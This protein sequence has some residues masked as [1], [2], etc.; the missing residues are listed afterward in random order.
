MKRTKE[1]Q[2]EKGAAGAG[3]EMQ[4]ISKEKKLHRQIWTCDGNLVVPSQR[5]RLRLRQI[6]YTDLIQ[7]KV[8]RYTYL[9]VFLR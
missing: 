4:E 1:E 2:I 7:K 3:A 8:N 6:I 5:L 9:A